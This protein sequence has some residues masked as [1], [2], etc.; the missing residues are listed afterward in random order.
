[1]KP[2]IRH[3]VRCNSEEVLRRSLLHCHATNLHSIM[4]LEAPGK[5]IRL[6]IAEP[7][8]E[9]GWNHP[10]LFRKK[11]SIGFH[12]HHCDLTLIPIF[13][14]VLNWEVARIRNRDSFKVKE[15]KYQSKITHGKIGFERLGDDL[16]TTV[17]FLP[18][19]RSG[20]FMH[21]VDLHTVFV[22]EGQWAAWLVLEGKENFTHENH[23]LST[24][25]LDFQSFDHLY[26]PMDEAKLNQLLNAFELR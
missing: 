5:T 2:L 10:V 1:M 6:F 13:G 14:E 12:A 8:H 3:L 4:L 16:L 26:K 7:G 21:S 18:I 19:P 25:D 20:V 9:L 17:R 22:P 24:E 15:F 11:Q 23:V